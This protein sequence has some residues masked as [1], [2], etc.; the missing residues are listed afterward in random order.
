MNTSPTTGKHA[1]PYAGADVL[2]LNR[3]RAAV[4]GSVRAGALAS[5]VEARAGQD[6]RLRAR[7]DERRAARDR[8][9]PPYPVADPIRVE[10]DRSRSSKVVMATA[11][12]LVCLG[13]YGSAM[14]TLLFGVS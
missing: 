11:L 12:G 13:G 14:L 10:D 8:L 7:L 6:S 5:R 3:Y 9:R 1:G 2:E 4:T